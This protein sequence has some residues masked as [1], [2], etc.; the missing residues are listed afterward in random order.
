MYPILALLAGHRGWAGLK[1][2]PYKAGFSGENV[3]LK[4]GAWKAGAA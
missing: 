4:D 2:G 1:G 3:L